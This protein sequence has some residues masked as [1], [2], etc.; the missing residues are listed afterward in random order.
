MAEY[1]NGGSGMDQQAW[2][3]R[4]TESDAIKIAEKAA[5]KA[6]YYRSIG[7][8]EG[9]ILATMVTLVFALIAFEGYFYELLEWGMDQRIIDKKDYSK[10]MPLEERV[11]KGVCLISGRSVDKGRQPYQDFVLLKRIRNA[12][13]HYRPAWETPEEEDPEQIL[14]T[15][16][17]TNRFLLNENG[18]RWQEKLLTSSCAEW[19][20]KTTLKMIKYVHELCDLPCPKELE[21][22]L[23][24]LEKAS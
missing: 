1:L 17:S 7:D 5:A 21:T 3:R 14:K 19:A 22:R 8:L 2:L 18:A 9:E 24:D 20:Y 16:R 23:Q 6:C 4:K 11:E 15:V 10:I 13:V 12:L